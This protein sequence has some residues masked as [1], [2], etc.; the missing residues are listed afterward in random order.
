MYGRGG[1][2]QLRKYQDGL[3]PREIE[4]IEQHGWINNGDGT[5][6]PN[7]NP[8]TP[9]TNL[10]DET[11]GWGEVVGYHPYPDSDGDG[12]TDDIDEFPDDPNEDTYTRS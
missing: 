8:G 5:I 1:D 10:D 7:D 4:I 11:F 12:L 9:K 2:G 6:S 3:H